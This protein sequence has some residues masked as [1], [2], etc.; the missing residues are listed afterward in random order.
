MIQKTS[1]RKIV[2]SV[3]IISVIPAFGQVNLEHFIRQGRIALYKNEYSEAIKHF[4]VV[5]ER[6]KDPFEEYFYRGIAKYNLGDYRGAAFDF[7]QTVDI[8]PFYYRAYHYRGVTYS[9]MMEKGKAIKDLDEALSLDPYN[10]EILI[11]RGTVYLQ[12]GRFKKAL[13]D[14]DEAILIDGSIPQAYLNRAITHKELEN[15]VEALND[16]NRAIRENNFFKKAFAERGLIRYEMGQ[17]D[18]ALKDFNQALKLDENNSRYFYFKALTLYKLGD[19]EGTLDNYSKVLEL[20]PTNALTYYN[21][22]IIYSQVKE[23]EAAIQDLN[24]V[25]ALNP[26]NMLTYFNRGHIHYKLN[27]YERAIED[28]T[29]VIEL[30]PK[31]A[32]GYFM[33]AEARQKAGDYEAA[34]KDRRMGNLLLEEH[35]RFAKEGKAGQWVD[36][37]Y[38]SKIIEFEADFRTGEAMAGADIS[39]KTRIHPEKNFTFSL[40]TENNTKGRSNSFVSSFNQNEKYGIKLILSNENNEMPSS[41]LQMLM[42]KVDS[43]ITFSAPS[44]ELYLLKGIINQQIQNLTTAISNYNMAMVTEPYFYPAYL[45]H[46][47]ALY[48]MKENIRNHT[49]ELQ[50]ISLGRN[51]V[52]SGEQTEVS[53]EPVLKDLNNA[54]SLKSAV[55]ETWFNQGNTL[56]TLKKHANAVQSYSMAINLDKDFGEAYYNRGLT[57]IYLQDSRRGCTDM[58]KAGELGIDAAYEVIRKYCND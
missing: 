36:S 28:Y 25:A 3:L 41:K 31:S 52:S 17:F 58:S 55:P 47:D 9:S 29:R 19:I 8:H 54:L 40:L 7:T 1:L 27:E 56:L 12:M 51:Q 37:T 50:N 4:N 18:E 13:D 38:F 26:N 10:A 53:Y 57:L 48:E 42:D 34:N 43:L 22:A 33:R 24:R 15:Y 2:L 14:F 23:Y 35:D 11:S 46:A 49:K 32:R 20:D 5:I 45:N 39:E 30:F 6:K 16:C 21:R 44:A